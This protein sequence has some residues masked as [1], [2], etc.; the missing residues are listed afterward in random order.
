MSVIV[1][2]QTK[3][4][5]K[6]GPGMRSERIREG[7]EFE[8]LWPLEAPEPGT[9]DHLPDTEKWRGLPRGWKIV[10]T[11]GAAESAERAAKLP[12]TTLDDVR[13]TATNANSAEYEERGVTAKDLDIVRA[14]V[15]ELDPEDPDLFTS[16]G[17][18]RVEAVALQ[19]E[20]LLFQETRTRTYPNWLKR[21]HITEAMKGS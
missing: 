21:E 11:V 14:A 13:N 2:A 19:V 4:E 7:Q 15:G 12:K 5:Q 17:L 20:E 16:Q 8:W 9:E 10:R 3:G 18:P 1:K 6:R